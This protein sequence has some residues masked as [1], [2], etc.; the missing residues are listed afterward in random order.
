MPVLPLEDSTSTS[1][2]VLVFQ[3]SC[4]P[5]RQLSPEPCCVPVNHGLYTPDM[6]ENWTTFTW[7][8][9]ADYLTLSG[10]IPDTEVLSRAC[11]PSINLNHLATIQ[12][13]LGGPR[14]SYARCKTLKT[15]FVW[16]T[17][18]WKRSI[19]GKRKRFNDRH[20]I[21]EQTLGFAKRCP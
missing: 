15:A 12:S 18:I 16:W 1:A 9:Y 17:V 19:G 2:S 13:S 20:D 8:A 5:I 11:K 3:P 6:P 21:T 10:K 7:P 4:I 14:L